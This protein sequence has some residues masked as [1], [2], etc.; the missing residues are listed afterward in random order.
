MFYFSIYCFWC[1]APEAPTYTYYLTSSSSSLSADAPFAPDLRIHSW[2]GY[3]DCWRWTICFCGR[4]CFHRFFVQATASVR[5]DA[6]IR[7]D[8][9]LL[10]NKH[11]ISLS[12]VSGCL[13]FIS[14]V[15]IVDVFLLIS[16]SSKQGNEKLESFV[17]AT[18]TLTFPR[19]LS[20]ASPVPHPHWILT[21]T[22]TNLTTWF[23]R[24]WHSSGEKD[25]LSDKALVWRWRSSDIYIYFYF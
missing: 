18:L 17:C 5:L 11:E 2:W 21:D 15:A 9:P 20:L 1:F 22:E 6:V 24:T 14:F 8:W 19:C 25:G 4:V 12:Y 23:L 16:N 10:S 3:L 7:L 13:F